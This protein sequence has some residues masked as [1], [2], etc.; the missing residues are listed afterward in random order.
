MRVQS[1]ACDNTATGA[2][3]L[4]DTSADGLTARIT[5]TLAYENAARLYICL[6]STHQGAA[7]LLHLEVL[8]PV[9]LTWA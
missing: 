1:Q 4:F 2:T 6:D 9:F 8:A 5:V 3:L 7:E